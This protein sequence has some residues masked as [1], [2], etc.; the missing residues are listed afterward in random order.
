MCYNDGE[1]KPYER[2]II[3][4][5]TY[6][7]WKSIREALKHELGDWTIQECVLLL[8]HEGTNFFITYFCDRNLRYITIDQPHAAQYAYTQDNGSQVWDETDEEVPF[9]IGV[10]ALK[11]Y[12]RQQAATIA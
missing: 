2:R 1:E 7:I 12:Y 6:R 9:A 4:K 5:K 11:N 10:E 8:N 3:M